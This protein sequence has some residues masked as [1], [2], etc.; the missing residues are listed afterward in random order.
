MLLNLR[1]TSPSSFLVSAGITD[2][3]YHLSP[4]RYMYSNMFRSS[5]WIVNLV[6]KEKMGADMNNN[7][8]FC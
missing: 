2:I 7:F 6:S 1:L 4:H 5:F 3:R 8:S